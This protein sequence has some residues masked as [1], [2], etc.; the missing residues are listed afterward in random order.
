MIMSLVWV[1]GLNMILSKPGKL[2]LDLLYYNVIRRLL[3]ATLLQE[4]TMIQI[5]V[6]LT[7]K[8]SVKFTDYETQA[9]KIMAEHEG[10]L[11]SAFT[12]DENES[13]DNFVHEV[14]ILEFPS[15]DLFY[16]YKNNPKLQQLADL[17]E[18]AIGKTTMYM[19]DK[20]RDY[21]SNSH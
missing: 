4:E 10:H 18:Q 12:P 9:I 1:S 7:I 14:H 2:M 3:R 6:L 15:I 5:I 20:F 8:D 19:S 21:G 16:A 17:R 13:T 11:I